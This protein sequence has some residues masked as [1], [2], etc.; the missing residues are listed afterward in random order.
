MQRSI[1]DWLTPPRRAA[2][3]ICARHA[4][5]ADDWVQIQ[6]DLDGLPGA[7]MPR[8]ASL[9]VM[10]YRLGIKQPTR[11][12]LPKRQPTVAELIRLPR[13]GQEPVD[14]RTLIRWACHQMVDVRGPTDVVFARVNDARKAAGLPTWWVDRVEIG[15]GLVVRLHG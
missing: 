14:W 12:R 9:R 7:P 6:R 13:D 1:D 4:R 5:C 11:R 10:T 2:L 8:P 15:N 3:S